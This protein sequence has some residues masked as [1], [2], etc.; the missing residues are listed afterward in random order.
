MPNRILDLLF[1]PR[2]VQ[3]GAYA[4]G[5]A[6]CTRCAK[7]IRI[8]HSLFCGSCRA[9]LP[10][11]L[12]ICHKSFPYILGAAADYDAPAIRSL[13]HALKFRSM[14]NAAV[15]LAEFLICYAATIPL[16]ADAL[17][18]PVP[19]SVRRRRE[20]GFNQAELIGGIFAGRFRMPFDPAALVRTK[21]AKPQSETKTLAERCENVKNC[22]AVPDA[23]RVA[24][25]NIILID[26]VTTS[27]TTFL[28]AASALKSAG[29]KKIIAL[30]A[31]KA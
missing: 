21:H 30:A 8:H 29:A 12:K 7:S 22:F 10:E 5:R 2:C 3:C 16:P 26:D 28:E 20:R 6:L 24:D 23:A 4:D 15:P 19:L 18:V 13:I 31:A 9:R 17:A 1:P 14:Q 11:G 27:G 25:R